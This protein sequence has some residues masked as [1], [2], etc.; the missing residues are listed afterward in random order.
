MTVDFYHLTS[1]PL[2][3]VLPQ[4]CE[5]ILAGG[6]RLLVV[7][8]PD[9]LEQLDDRL[10]GYARDAFIPHGKS[11]APYAGSQPVLLSTSVEAINGA[12]NVA[13]VDGVWRDEALGFSRTFYFFGSGQLEDARASWRSLK[14]R[15]DTELR[16]WKQDEAGKWVQ[17]P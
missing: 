7:A 4:I 10:W 9:L 14:A 13:L 5:K 8:G 6:E 3:R 17:G 12:S 2:D 11:D 1:S 15:K 16:Y